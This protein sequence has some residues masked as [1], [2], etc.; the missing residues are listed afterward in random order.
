M[1]SGSGTLSVSPTRGRL[2]KENRDKRRASES[3]EK[4]MRRRDREE[5]LS[6]ECKPFLLPV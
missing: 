3:K 6:V 5:G 2:R 4:W 1:P